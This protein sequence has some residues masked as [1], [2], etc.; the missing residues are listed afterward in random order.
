MPHSFRRQFAALGLFAALAAPAVAQERIIVGTVHGD[1]APLADATVVARGTA[2]R[3]RTDAEGRFRLPIAGDRDSLILRA[4]AIGFRPAERLVRADDPAVRFELERRPLDL[5]P[6]VVTG[7]LN[8][9]SVSESPVKVEVVSA[10]FL[11]R[12]VTNNLMESVQ[13]LNGLIQ[14]VDCGVCYTNNIRI[15][16]M[17]GPYTAVLIDGAPIMSSLATVYG[18]NGINPAIVEQVEIVKGP[19]STLYGSEAMAGVINVITKDPRFAPVYSVSAYGTTHG[20]TNL[21]FAAA[22]A[23]AGVRALLSGSLARNR[24]FVDDNGDGFTDLPLAGRAAFFGKVS[25]G[26]R[27]RPAFDLSAKYYYEDRFGGVR[28]W[29]R[30]DRGSDRIYGES[31]FTNR[32]ELLGA[33]QPWGRALRVE[34]AYNWH[35]QDS[36][37]GTTQYLGKQQTLYGQLT[38]SRAL[39]TRHR[40]LLGATVRHQHYDDN[41]TA[42]AAP[43]RRTVPGV[44]AQDEYALSESLTLLGGLRLDRHAAHGVIASPRLSA[45]WRVGSMTTIRVNTATGFRVVNLFTEDHAALSGFREVTI[46]EAL[47]PERSVTATVSLNQIVPAGPLA[48]TLDVDGFVTRFSN[49]IQPDYNTDPDRIIYANLRGHAVTRGVS[50]SLTL[51]AGQLPFSG[52][53]G[54]SFQDVYTAT[55]GARAPLEFAPRF[56]GEATL[57]YELEEPGLT[58]D[59]TGRVV[60]PM[61]LPRFPDRAERSP[62]FSEHNLQATLRVAPNTFVIGA[63]KNLFDYAQPDPLVHPEDPFGPDFDTFYVY[64][65]VQGRRLLLGLQVNRSR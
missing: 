50:A 7:T 13:S 53:I 61:Q 43:D 52:R 23:I 64:G 48:L 34:A 5:D 45:K 1:G 38:W 19:S 20:E 42:T 3:A 30:A 49:K 4:T 35:R 14:Q 54:G 47:R 58:F 26:T 57:S 44:F 10:R 15:N 2:A 36:Y 60:G 63:V 40:L 65:P 16:G 27:A 21:D 55:D 51:P 28:G 22:P 6:L 11:Q 8:E 32:L 37:Y 62:W 17:E 59:Y 41:T 33:A 25:G 31:I 56:K 9:T 29:T 39:G 46:A 12:N 24:E 18:L